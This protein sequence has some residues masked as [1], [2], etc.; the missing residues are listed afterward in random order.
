ML[1][2][3]LCLQCNRTNELSSLYKHHD[4][5]E[6]TEEEVDRD[7]RKKVS[8]EEAGQQLCWPGF[9]SSRLQLLDVW[10][11]LQSYSLTCFVCLFF[12]CQPVFYLWFRLHGRTCCCPKLCATLVQTCIGTSLELRRWIMGHGVHF[13]QFKVLFQHGQVSLDLE[14][15]QKKM[16]QHICL[17]R[18]ISFLDIVIQKPGTGSFN[19]SNVLSDW[20]KP[21]CTKYKLL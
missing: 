18:D 13:R 9:L 12:Y 17:L 20:G 21:N 16:S 15:Q 5:E 7:E 10:L 2:K 3:H 11:C 1:L 19:S 8:G 14:I 4:W 6:E